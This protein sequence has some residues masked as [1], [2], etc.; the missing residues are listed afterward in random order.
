MEFSKQ[1]PVTFEYFRKNINFIKKPHNWTVI[2]YKTCIIFVQVL[3]DLQENM[4]LIINYNL[5]IEIL[6]HNQPLNWITCEKM[7]SMEQ[8]SDVIEILQR[9]SIF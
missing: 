1:T 7:Q 4:K 9:I 5:E 3:D 6:R 8:L 2:D